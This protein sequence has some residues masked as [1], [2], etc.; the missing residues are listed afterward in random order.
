[1]L[2]LGMFFLFAFAGA[3]QADLNN[4]NVIEEI[5]NSSRYAIG[6]YTNM[7]NISFVQ[8]ELKIN[9]T[10]SNNLTSGYN[11]SVFVDGIVQ[12]GAQGLIT[13][14]T[15]V[16]VNITTRLANGTHVV[17]VTLN[18]SD[19]TN[20]L[21]NST[22]VTFTVDDTKPIVN[23]SSG[24]GSTTNTT[25]FTDTTPEIAFNITDNGFTAISYNV[26]VNNVYA[27]TPTATNNTINRVNLTAL[28][29]GTYVIRIEANDSARN[30]V[31]GTINLTI[32]VDDTIP[33]VAFGYSTV[34][35]TNTTDTT[36]GLVIN[37]TDNF[38]LLD[39]NLTI[40]AN[41]A[42][43][44]I[45][46]WVANATN[47]TVNTSGLTNGTYSIQIQVTDPAG[48]KV[49]STVMTIKVDDTKPVFQPFDSGNGTTTNA[50]NSSDITPEILINMTDNAQTDQINVSIYIDG[51][52]DGSLLFTNNTIGRYN[53]SAR[54]NDTVRVRVEANDSAGNLA[55][56]SLLTLYVYDGKPTVNILSFAT[57]ATNTTSF[58]QTIIFNLT[59]TGNYTNTNFLNYTIFIDGAANGT[60]EFV[61]NDT[62]ITAIV[63]GFRNG[64][65]SIWVQGVDPAGNKANSTVYTITTD[66]EAPFAN[67]SSPV[68]NSNTSDVTPTIKFTVIDN[69]SAFASVLNYT[70]FVDGEVNGQTG[71]ATNNSEVELVLSVMTN[72]S[73]NITI[74][75]KDFL[76]NTRNLTQWKIVTDAVPPSSLAISISPTNVYK[77]N[78]VTISCS[79]SDGLSGVSGPA[80]TLTVAKPT[81]GTTSLSACGAEF[82]DTTG[83]GTYTITYTA[84]DYAG[85]SASKTLAFESNDPGSSSSSSSSGGSS[86]GG[87]STPSTTF[88][89]TLIIDAFTSDKPN[90]VKLTSETIG[91]K[92][93]SVDVNNKANSVEIKVTKTDAA[94]ATVTKSVEGKVYQYIEIKHD[95]LADSNIKSAKVKFTVT[96]KWFN[97]NL[98]SRSNVVLKRYSNGE[99]SDMPTTF[100]SEDT[101]EVTFEAELPGLSVFAIGEKVATVEQQPAPEPVAEPQQQP[102]QGEEPPVKPLVPEQTSYQAPAYSI[103]AYGTVA[104]V[105]I[106]L[107]LGFVWHKMSH[108][109]KPKKK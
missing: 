90:V 2:A 44:G 99:W 53:L 43:T 66:T 3:S 61:N 6:N 73:H 103:E 26:Y 100:V 32:N 71:L 65:H 89:K 105:V 18:S 40:F 17:I 11:Y 36:P 60:S 48:N 52:Y 34:N 50:T 68:N 95:K 55:N 51:T 81:G 54:I 14:N 93:I 74:Q 75:V 85:N 16:F 79:A 98:V 72:S 10:G 13:N 109:G 1:M 39:I 41:G 12:N 29:N 63:T 8:P 102:V 87:T 78:V 7:S 77:G 82:S 101:A 97:D 23:L 33:A 91:F 47:V 15:A 49:N 42:V 19:D 37:A 83:G 104:A 57:N 56:A 24:T 80:S 58:T 28:A 38:A 27:A 25:N 22:N 45:S 88:S 62:N 108:K 67:I 4:I 9:F 21:W 70:I 94:P 84:V 30:L 46:Q 92:E 5:R 64:T 107:I 20:T 69:S 96:K 106:L 35:A 76:N 31:N 86:G 59:R